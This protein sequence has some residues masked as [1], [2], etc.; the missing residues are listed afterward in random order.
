MQEGLSQ[1]PDT[2]APPNFLSKLNTFLHVDL[3]SIVYLHV[4][5]ILFYS[6]EREQEGKT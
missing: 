6:D 1:N 4:A 5:Q 2:F 3:T